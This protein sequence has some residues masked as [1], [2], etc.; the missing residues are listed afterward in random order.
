[1]FPRVVTAR[2]TRHERYQ[3]VLVGAEHLYRVP[4]QH[5]LVSARVVLGTG[6]QATRPFLQHQH[7]EEYQ[8]PVPEL[9]HKF[10]KTCA[11]VDSALSAF[12]FQAALQ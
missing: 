12:V 9:V 8:R 7:L 1:M 11:H 2:I 5:H 4:K 3:R 6:V 10:A